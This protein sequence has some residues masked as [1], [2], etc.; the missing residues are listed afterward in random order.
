MRVYP[1]VWDGC[2]AWSNFLPK[3]DENG[4]ILEQ[5]QNL[6]EDEEDKEEDEEKDE[7]NSSEFDSEMHQILSLMTTTYLGTD[8]I[9]CI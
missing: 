7:D 2:W 3:Y 8:I 9:S 1:A 4:E 6:Y 5:E